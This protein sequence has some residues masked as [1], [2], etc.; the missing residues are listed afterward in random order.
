MVTIGKAK[1]TKYLSCLAPWKENSC[2][3]KLD[4]Q[5]V[6]GT[7]NHCSVIL[8]EGRSRLPSLYQFVGMFKPLENPFVMHKISRQAL[9]DIIWWHNQLS[10]PWCS[11]HICKIPEPLPSQIF[12]DA[13][14]S[15]GI[16]FIWE[17]QWL[18][19]KLLLGWKA[20]GHEIGWAEMV[21][22][23]L[24]YL[25]VIAAGFSNCHIILRSDNQGVVGA[26]KNNA[27]CNQQQNAIL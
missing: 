19:W 27:S 24:A 15:W 23:E 3:T 12:V 4:V 6:I 17:D 22:V 2:F 10:K 9:N 16:G 13:S 11:V 25:T 26:L 14:T 18:A 8:V 1:C 5:K 7:L 20:E 21:A